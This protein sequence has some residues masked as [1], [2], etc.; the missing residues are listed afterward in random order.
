MEKNQ[1]TPDYNRMYNDDEFGYPVTN[2][3]YIYPGRSQPMSTMVPVQQ[4]Y[5]ETVNIPNYF[6][7]S[8]LSC[9]FC[10]WPVGI[11]AILKSQEVNNALAVNDI[12]RAR[13]ASD[14]AKKY[15]IIAFV[16]GLILIPVVVV[17]RIMIASQQEQR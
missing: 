8:L 10:C 1:P 6:A 15:A 12:P 3:P 4:P 9:I 5:A 14:A 2:Q 7:I 11:A 13:K 16:L 17:T